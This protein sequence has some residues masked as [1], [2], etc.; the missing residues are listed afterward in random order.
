MKTDDL[1]LFRQEA[2]QAKNLNGLG[3]VVL[4]P[5]PRS[6]TVLFG[7]CAV[8]VLLVVALCTMTYT[9]KVR[10]AGQLIPSSGLVTVLAPS[11]AVVVSKPVATGSYVGLGKELLRLSTER[12]ISDGGVHAKAYQSFQATRILLE[13][14]RSRHIM[15]A[16]QQKRTF[17]E[18]LEFLGRM[19][20]S[21]TQQQL[22]L[23]QRV[24]LAEQAN[25]R[26]LELVERGYVSQGLKND[27]LDAVLDMRSRVRENEKNIAEIDGQIAALR[28]SIVA[29]EH[30]LKITLAGIGKNILAVQQSATIAEGDRQSVLTAPISGSVADSN[31][32]QGQFVSSGQSLLSIVPESSELE[33]ILIVRSDKIGFLKKG[34]LVQLRYQAFPYQKFGQYRGTVYEIAKSPMSAQQISTLFGSSLGA[35]RDAAY[36]VTVRLENQFVTLYGEK[37]RLVAG[38]ALEAD[39]SLDTRRLIEWLLQ[40]VLGFREKTA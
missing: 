39:I 19:R 8:L 36:K 29:A 9:S 7:L 40:P 24:D 16:E 28:G 14:E 37:Q 4:S 10:V 32:A 25:K 21:N 1:P 17:A 18:K 13:G 27:K 33:A 30:E 35:D 26:W 11:S 2:I 23:Q 31:V 15:M 3:T 38:L 12:E 22:L 20:Q 6:T 5:R 34:Q